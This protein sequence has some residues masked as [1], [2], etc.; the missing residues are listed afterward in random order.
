MPIQGRIGLGDRRLGLFFRLGNS[1]CHVMI[2]D[3]PFSGPT[4]LALP[5]L[6]PALRHAVAV[7]DD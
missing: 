5:V 4:W 6:E 3:E 1:D 2:K 7:G